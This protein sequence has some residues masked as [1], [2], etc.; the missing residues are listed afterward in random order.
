M[1]FHSP[2]LIVFFSISILFIIGMIIRPATKKKTRITLS[3][4]LILLGLSAVFYPK[5]KNSF[6]SQNTHLFADLKKKTYSSRLPLGTEF[7]NI[8]NETNDKSLTSEK[9]FSGTKSSKLSKEMEYGYTVLKKMKDIPSYEKLKTIQV[10]LKCWMEPDVN[11]AEYVLSIDAP[12]G[13]N[14]SWAFKPIASSKRNEWVTIRMTFGVKPEA[15]NP[16]YTLKFYPWNKEKKNFYIDDIS[17][18][19]NGNK[20]IDSTVGLQRFNTNFFYD[21]ET[22]QPDVINTQGIE[23]GIAHSGKTSCSIGSEQLHS[24][25]VVKQIGEFCTEPVKKVC[26]SVWVYPLVDSAVVALEA[27]IVNEKQDTLFSE[28]QIINGKLLPKNKWTKINCLVKLP[29]EELSLDDFIAVDLLNKGKT[30]LLMDDLEIVYGE[31]NDRRGNNSGMDPDVIYNKQFSAE[32]NK[33]PFIPFLFNKKEI[34][35]NNSTY[36]LP[37]ISNTADFAPADE[38]MVGDFGAD[39]EHLD[40][41]LQISK[42]DIALYGYCSGQSK[43]ISLTGNLNTFFSGKNYPDKMVADFDNNGTDD[44]LM[45]NKKE[46]KAEMISFTSEVNCTSGN[47]LTPVSSWKGTG[48]VFTNWALSENDQF[49]TADFS[50][51]RKKD[52]L[53][54]NAANGEWGIYQFSADKKWSAY[55]RSNASNKLDPTFFDIN[56]SKTVAGHFYSDKQN[57]ILF[58]SRMNK[59]DKKQEYA[60]FEFNIAHKSFEQQQIDPEV[61]TGLLFGKDNSC[62]VG[63]FDDD[64]QQEFLSLNSSW[65]FDLKLVDADAQG[66]YIANTVDFKGYPADHNPKYYEFVKLVAGNFISRENTALLVMMRNCSDSNFNGID[67]SEYENSTALPNSTQLYFIK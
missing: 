47:K 20:A 58:A 65:R 23:E 26:A 48:D 59:T 5:I 28:G 36:L 50:G 9:A 21:F 63:N 12:D 19:Y 46:K 64:P 31:E 30:E 66:L 53:I 16:E 18:T 22:P 11:D 67:C 34:G 39:K 41:V 14:I 51:D 56:N 35:N 43:F 62:F 8:E 33:P 7:F 44:L 45:I 25:A 17:I 37:G 60:A 61:A 6:A 2:L 49:I 15:I 13:K 55:A 29:Y 10:E 42:N 1:F 27:I 57:D 40:E 52:L 38:F 3:F 32:R 24:P 4:L 54:V